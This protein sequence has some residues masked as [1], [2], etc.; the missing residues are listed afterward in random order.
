MFAS[1]LLVASFAAGPDPARELALQLEGVWDNGAQIAEAADPNRPHLNVRHV[2]FDSGAAD[3]ALVYAE[4]RVGGPEGELYRQR[5]YAING[6]PDGQALTMAVWSLADPD[7][8][9]G[10]DEAVLAALTAEDLIRFDPGCDFVWRYDEAGWTGAMEDGAC[11]VASR[12]L[13][14]EMIISAE[15]TIIQDRFTHSES[16]RNAET[17]EAVFGPPN[18]VPNLYDR[19]DE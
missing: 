14:V 10:A 13:G 8:A 6:A 2:A 9:A 11:R 7:A 19:V 4:L 17:G 15:F 5:V 1:A 18:G 3:G 16:G 12:R